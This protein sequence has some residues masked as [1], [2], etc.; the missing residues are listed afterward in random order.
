MAKITSVNNEPTSAANSIFILKQTLKS[1]GWTV[2]CS[3]N[4]TTYNSTGD[5]ISTTADLET[6]SAWFVIEDPAGQRQFCFQR[7][8]TDLLWRILVSDSSKFTGGSPSATRVPDA[9]DQGVLFGSGTNASPTFAV[10]FVDV[11]TTPYHCHVITYDEPYENTDVYGFYFF[12]SD[13]STGLCRTMFFVDA[14]KDSHPLD[15]CPYVILNAYLTVRPAEAN[16]VNSNLSSNIFKKYLK[17]NVFSGVRTVVIKN[18]G[19]TQLFPPINTNFDLSP[20]VWDDN[21]VL[22]KILHFFTAKND[23][24]ST[25]GFHGTAKTIAYTTSFNRYYPDTFNLTTDDPYVCV[26]GVFAIPWEKNTAAQN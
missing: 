23:N 5:E 8:A 10:Y 20:S 18:N 3:S 19:N 15:P 4:G 16:F 12:T 26:G 9:S 2:P 7:G 6:S 1:A 24:A 13:K 11:A 25:Y 17:G 21:E 14:L 22:L